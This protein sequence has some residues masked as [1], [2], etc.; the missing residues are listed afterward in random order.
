MNCSASAGLNCAVLGVYFPDAVARGV[1]ARDS[2]WEIG[3]DRQP[4]VA[5]RDGRMQ[6][7]RVAYSSK[8]GTPRRRRSMHATLSRPHPLWTQIS[9]PQEGMWTKMR[10]AVRDRV[11]WCTRATGTPWSPSGRA[12]PMEFETAGSVDSLKNGPPLLQR[13][14]KVV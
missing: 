2:G 9:I 8:L 4:T 11:T 13:L 10:P 3:K 14:G 5:L 6:S 12:K 1:D 7:P